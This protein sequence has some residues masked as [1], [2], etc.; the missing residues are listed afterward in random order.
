RMRRASVVAGILGAITWL[1]PAYGADAVQSRGDERARG[2][3]LFEREWLPGDSRAHGGDGLGPADNDSSCVACHN[4]GATG[5][6][7]PSSK[8]VDIV[9]AS[10]NMIVEMQQAAGETKTDRPGFLG[11]ALGSLVGR[12]EPEGARPGAPR[13][14]PGGR[15]KPDTR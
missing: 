2:R 9:T 15:H 10:P 6:A 8:N 13:A 7:G 1:G 11:R 5:G 3:E 4:L 12:D 14:R